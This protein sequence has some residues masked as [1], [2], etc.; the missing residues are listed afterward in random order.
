MTDVEEIRIERDKL[1][2]TCEV[3]L[4]IIEE[5]QQKLHE[6]STELRKRRATKFDL[7]PIKE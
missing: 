3:L 6:L 5:K 1:A 2:E 7:N 4:Q